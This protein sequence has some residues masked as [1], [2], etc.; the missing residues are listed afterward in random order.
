MNHQQNLSE[1]LPQN[2]ET[3]I[4]VVLETLEALG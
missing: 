3:S 1:D 2:W 4:P